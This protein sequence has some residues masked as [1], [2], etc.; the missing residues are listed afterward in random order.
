[1]N[2]LQKLSD[3]LNKTIVKPLTTAA[4]KTY[5]IATVSP[6]TQQKAQQY[7]AK[8]PTA[9]VSKAVISTSPQ[10][11]SGQISPTT[12]QKA[13][14][15][16]TQYP[17]SPVTQAL[18][19]Q[20]QQVTNPYLS[21]AKSLFSWLNQPGAQVSPQ[22]YGKAV[23]YTL[24]NPLKPVSQAF[25]QTMT[26]SPATDLMRQALQRSA[27][28][29]Q[30]AGYT[31]EAE[32]LKGLYPTLGVNERGE[33]TAY[34][35]RSPF[36]NANALYSWLSS[37]FPDMYGKEGELQGQVGAGTAGY[38]KGYEKVF[39]QSQAG[40]SL[41]GT[42]SNWMQNIGKP[43]VAQAAGMQT[44]GPVKWN[45]PQGDL[46]KMEWT[47]LGQAEQAPQGPVGTQPGGQKFWW[48]GGELLGPPTPEQMNTP[49]YIKGYFNVLLDPATQEQYGY[50]DKNGKITDKGQAALDNAWDM[51]ANDAKDGY[52]TPDQIG[53]DT[54]LHQNLTEQ[55]LYR[56]K[57]DKK[58]VESLK[59]D[60]ISSL[61]TRVGSNDR[62]KLPP[63]LSQE[64]LA[65]IPKGPN[66][67]ILYD[68]GYR[69]KK[70]QDEAIAIVKQVQDA[71][72][73]TGVNVMF[74][75]EI[76]NN[77]EYANIESLKLWINQQPPEFW[78]K[79]AESGGSLFLNV[80][81]TGKF[82]YKDEAI[83]RANWDWEYA[84]D[85]GMK[86]SEKDR[87]IEQ[88]RFYNEWYW[89]EEAVA[90][91]AKEREESWEYYHEKDLEGWGDYYNMLDGMKLYPDAYEYWSQP[92]KFQEL[93]RKWETTGGGVDWNTWLQQFDF[94]GEWYRLSPTERGEKPYIYNPRMI[95]INY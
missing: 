15:Y 49:E 75:P 23:D 4:S 7:V 17:T 42:L 10:V 71:L 86:Q 13:A 21:Q 84:P 12:Y 60:N 45:I 67:G 51:M 5:P 54:D 72:A 94:E 47:P 6:T 70:Y 19:Q 2:L 28:G 11:R 50:F 33:Q 3:W 92:G 61:V 79:L 38:W 31:A 77:L 37:K 57:Y 95:R 48:E 44:P 9:P 85:T 36:Q 76:L 82:N 30:I 90:Q 52:Y 26:P 69:L 66:F 78:Q 56:D 29:Q 68:N 64:Y 27:L 73:G 55:M 81:D 53:K 35:P 18:Q 87:Y 41:L 16:Q 32:G 22:T 14:S 40:Q 91:R 58:W 39:G 46:S 1:M 25:S 63:E 59:P 80:T 74:K 65:T 89:S 83:Y 62:T 43:N 88:Q 93:R 8:Y 34:M 20:Y 24:A